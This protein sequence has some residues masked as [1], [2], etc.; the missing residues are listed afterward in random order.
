M[1]EENN[2]IHNEIAFINYHT[3]DIKIILPKLKEIG[4]K[5]TMLP[6]KYGGPLVLATYKGIVM[7]PY[8]VSIMK[9][10]ENFRYGVAMILPSEKLFKELLKSK[11]YTFAYKKINEIENGV[12]NYVEFYNNEFKDLFVYFNKWEDLPEIVEKTNFDELKTKGKNYIKKY[13]EK[14]LNIWAQVLD[15]KPPNDLIVDEKPLC[16]NTE[17]YNYGKK[18]PRKRYRNKPRK[19]YRKINKKK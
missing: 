9:M 4:I 14:A 3:Q 13:E 10:M 16:D 8:Q 19:R 6:Y 7:L 18:K 2:E 1:L 5:H 11:N 17:F 12:S 15:I